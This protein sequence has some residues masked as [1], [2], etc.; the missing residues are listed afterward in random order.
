MSPV[1]DSIC[2][3]HAI[4]IEDGRI[5]LTNFAQE[6]GSSAVHYSS[7]HKQLGYRNGCAELV[8]KSLT[9]SHKAHCMGLYAYDTLC[10]SWTAVFP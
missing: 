1:S 8:P 5:T 3:E 9:D 2:Y 7:V 4:I 10:Q 6:L